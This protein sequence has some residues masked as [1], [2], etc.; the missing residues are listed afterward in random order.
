LILPTAPN[1]PIRLFAR[2]PTVRYHLA[3]ITTRQRGFAPLTAVGR[4]AD[5]FAID[6]LDLVL[7]RG[8]KNLSVRRVLLVGAAGWRPR[9]RSPGFEPV[10]IVELLRY[11]LADD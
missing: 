1:K 5:I 2:S 4:K 6:L 9:R 10:G 3:V 7:R 8:S 11:A